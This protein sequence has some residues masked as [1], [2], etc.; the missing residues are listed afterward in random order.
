[1]ARAGWL[2]AAAAA[3]VVLVGC[4]RGGGGEPGAR[5][6]F[7]G[8]GPVSESGVGGAVGSVGED[9]GLGG[10]V[11]R[12]DGGSVVGEDVGEVGG[13]GGVVSSGGVPDLG[14]GEGLS[15]RARRVCA[16]G[17]CPSVP[18]LGAGVGGVGGGG[19]AG[20][21]VRVAGDGVVVEG[22]VLLRCKSGRLCE[23][24]DGDVAA[25]DVAD[26]CGWPGPLCVGVEGSSARREGGRL[27][28]RWGHP[29]PRWGRW[30]GEVLDVCDDHEALVVY[31]EA[32]EGW[33]PGGID[34][35]AAIAAEDLQAVR[36]RRQ[37]DGV[38]CDAAGAGAGRYVYVTHLGPTGAQP[39]PGA[40]VDA[41]RR[42]RDEGGGS[43]AAP[44][45]SPTG[46]VGPAFEVAWPAD[47]VVVVQETVSVA[48]G[49]LRGLAQNRSQSLWARNVSVEASD[50]AGG[51]GLW[52][53]PLAVQPGEVLPFEIDP[54]AGLTVP[55]GIGFEVS[56]DLT[57]IIDVTRSLRMN[58]IRHTTSTG[59]DPDP[60]H[61]WVV[62]EIPDAGDY[63]LVWV[64][65]E[66][67]P[68]TSHPRLA[69]DVAAA[70]VD[71]LRVYAAHIDPAGA[72]I[73]VFEPTPVT[74]MLST[75]D[76]TEIRTLPTQL[77]DGTPADYAVVSMI[78]DGSDPDPLVW[79]GSA[80]RTP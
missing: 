67:H 49:V 38:E 19:P 79:A 61:R 21:G 11:D 39:S 57:P 23:D 30:V 5:A 69:A 7:V 60:E 24:G 10:V 6:A 35:G 31:G 80:A 74:L 50:P 66:L 46:Y 17:D 36:D 52:R 2:V 70:R 1:M 13:V 9:P 54:W 18:D 62:G 45:E 77:P 75:F 76:H 8:G 68:P 63:D 27:W 12:S 58:H 53:F 33:S 41:Y 28:L 26:P 71:D 42:L 32:P 72:V 44:P 56:A 15:G 48:G 64:E 34:Y 43:S 14:A 51:E 37:A 47:S 73:D 4:G 78:L 3:V 59:D 40:A 25:L 22:R 29:D 65:I 55:S 20:S 16:V